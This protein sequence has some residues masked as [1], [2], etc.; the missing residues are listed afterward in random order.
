MTTPAP[1]SREI[2]LVQARSFALRAA[3][4]VTYRN[5][6]GRVHAELE[7]QRIRAKRNFWRSKFGRLLKA[8][9]LLAAGCG[10]GVAAVVYTP[11][12]TEGQRLNES[13]AS[14]LDA[15]GS[16]VHPAPAEPV[17]KDGLEDDS[18]KPDEATV[19]PISE[20]DQAT[21]SHFL[22]DGAPFL[23]PRLTPLPVDVRQVQVG[24]NTQGN[25]QA[26]N[27][28][29]R[30]VP[31]AHH[32]D[33]LSL[34]VGAARQ[35]AA[36]KGLQTQVSTQSS[37]PSIQPGVDVGLLGA[38]EKSRERMNRDVASNE[39]GLARKNN[40]AANLLSTSAEGQFTVVARFEWGHMIRQG[41]EVRP[42]RWGE[43]LP[44]G[45]ILEN[46]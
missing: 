2:A 21:L 28:S 40:K 26:K 29:P 3:A 6:I 25:E 30:E 31:I 20:V 38:I 27:A 46:K 34:S 5:R 19:D 22:L 45:R 35:R 36:S 33:E 15:Q 44:D 17:S 4:D 18:E 10:V 37:T 39:E 32:S 11:L 12:L 42:I 13:T 8:L 41:N 43:T 1:V 24:V 14:H 7:A 16:L 9:F 23:A